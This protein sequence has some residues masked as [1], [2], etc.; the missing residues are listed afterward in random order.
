MLTQKRMVR[1]H[2][3]VNMGFRADNIQ[4]YQGGLV[5]MNTATGLLVRASDSSTFVPLGLAAEDKLIAAEGDEMIVNLLEEAKCIWFK[6]DTG[7]GLIA[8]DDVGKTAHVVDDET[9]SINSA[10]NTAAAL[11]LILKVD[12]RKGVLVKVN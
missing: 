2:T 11:G 6:N 9:V 5:G 12:S 7:A 4:F 8:N 1:Q 3:A 10:Y